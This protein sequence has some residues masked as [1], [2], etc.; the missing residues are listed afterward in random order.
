[1]KTITQK[2]KKLSTGELEAQILATLQRL[3]VPG[4]RLEDAK[5]LAPRP[6]ADVQAA[7]KR[8]AHK[9]RLIRLAR[10]RY[11]LAT[12]DPAQAACHAWAP[13]YVSFLTVLA[14]AGFTDQIPRRLDLAYAQSVVRRSDWNRLPITWHPIPPDAFRGYVAQENRAL[15]ASPAKAAAD[16]VHRQRD[17]GGLTPYR[18]MIEAA[19]GR[20]PAA[21]VSEALE[22]Y[23]NH[24]GS[25]RRLLH[26][27]YGERAPPPQWTGRLPRD[28]HNPLALDP[29]RRASSAKP[30]GPMNI[31]E[32]KT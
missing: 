29:Q 13:S 31:V 32:A 14:D 30:Q 28:L 27:K 15:V 4:I 21:E 25:L 3:D 12:A 10:G 16:L 11:Y 22:A 7:L 18:F 9:G 20:R 1:M 17:F 5:R 24:S 23:A 8:L 2:D 6:T 26:L 19:L